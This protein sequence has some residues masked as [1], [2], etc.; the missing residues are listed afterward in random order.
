[1]REVETAV[2]ERDVQFRF[3]RIEDPFSPRIQHR[4]KMLVDAG[5]RGDTAK[6]MSSVIGF[7]RRDMPSHGA[8]DAFAGADY[9][10]EVRARDYYST[11]AA[12][13]GM[14]TTGGLG[15]SAPSATAAASVGGSAAST[16]LSSAHHP[17]YRTDIPFFLQQGPKDVWDVGSVDPDTIRRR[18]LASQRAPN[19]VFDT[20]S[21]AIILHALPDPVIRAIRE[22]D[23]IL[24]SRPPRP[25]DRP[26][27]FTANAT[28]LRTSRERSTKQAEVDM[29]RQLKP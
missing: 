8:A 2:R 1:M 13:A 26:A 10:G 24:R 11:L 9:G 12:T 27:S 6:R 29:V 15:S 25:V 5:L 14:A 23:E 16:S 7:G 20:T 19:R 28:M 22:N 18:A 4:A 21:P 17:G 3:F